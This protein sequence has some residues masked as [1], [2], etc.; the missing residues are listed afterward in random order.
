MNREGDVRLWGWLRDRWWLAIVV[1]LVVLAWPEMREWP[2]HTWV[3]VALA[4]A[5]TVFVYGAFAVGAWA[6]EASDRVWEAL[7]AEQEC[8]R[9]H[10]A[11]GQDGD[12][13]PVA[14]D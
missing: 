10:A 5:F 3:I 12:H 2:V 11:M 9:R 13:E 1:A 14:D 7:R 8:A 4:V 6:E